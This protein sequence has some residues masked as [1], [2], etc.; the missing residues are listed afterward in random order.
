MF[1]NFTCTEHLQWPSADSY[2]AHAPL[3]EGPGPEQTGHLRRA[4]EFWML[5]AR[6]AGPLQ[7]EGRA[8]PPVMGKREGS[9]ANARP[10][11]LAPARGRNGPGGELTRSPAGS[12]VRKAHPRVDMKCS[13][14]RG[15]SRGLF[16]DFD[17][18]RSFRA[19]SIA[20]AW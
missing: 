8:P 10:Q 4:G 16:A 9:R 15:H 6:R 12:L 17:R 3:R 19:G 1:L 7:R 11:R 18:T 20:G 13:F 5:A 2:S 14:L